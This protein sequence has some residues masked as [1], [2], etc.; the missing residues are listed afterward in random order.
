MPTKSTPLDATLVKGSH[1]YPADDASRQ[2]VL[3][4][5]DASVL[6]AGATH[7]RDVDV[8]GLV[9]RNFGVIQR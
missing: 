1:G 2:T 3:L 9:Y 8:A 4:C 7:L 6:P 5:S